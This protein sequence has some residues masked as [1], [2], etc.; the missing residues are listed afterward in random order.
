LRPP[1]QLANR[2]QG[3]E[4]Q[5]GSAKQPSGRF[6]KAQG[7]KG[8]LPPHGIPG[9]CICF[10]GS[11]NAPSAHSLRPIRMR[12]FDPDGPSENEWEDRGDLAWNEFDWEKY[13]REQ[14]DVLH[15]Y[16]AF[17]EQLRGNPER[18][19]EAAHLMGWDKEG[20]SSDS[21]DAEADDDAADSA[22]D[23][24]PDAGDFDSE[25]YTLQKNPVFIATKAIYLSLKR[26]WE[27]VGA[28]ATRVPQP[29]AL[30][31]LS[32]LHRGEEQAM[33]GIHALDFG[34]YAMAISL[35]K[36]A[37]RELNVS[38]SLLDDRAV[39]HSR[40]LAQFRQDAMHRLFDLREIWLRVMNE[41][42]QELERPADTDDDEEED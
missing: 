2:A 31:F 21:T 37:L 7:I 25:P 17:Y 22:A 28:D 8:L 29:L 34:D 9:F 20:W 15:R 1:P 38:L 41:C 6:G 4:M 42:R 26:A 35:F 32:S 30:A 13:L 5:R 12:N 16:L 40:A 24:R 11:R 23:D 33:L 19:D 14:D 39:G 18:L 10:L 36:R 27:R 3:P